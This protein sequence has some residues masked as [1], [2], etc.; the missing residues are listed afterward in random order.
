MN[1]K[2]MSYFE[3]VVV[4]HVEGKKIERFLAYLYKLNIP[5]LN[6][7]YVDRRNIIIKILNRDLDK[8][9]NMKTTYEINVTNYEG[10]LKLREGFRKN[11]FLLS[12]L[13]IGY[14][15]LLVLSNMIFDVEVIHSNANIR[16]LITEELKEHNIKRWSF[17]QNFK[18]IEKIKKEILVEYKDR[19]EWLE[20]ESIGTKYIV[21]VEE[22][23]KKPLETNYIFQDIVSTKNATIAAIYAT[24]GE[25]VKR[26]NDYVKKG[27][28]LI[29][30]KIMKGEEV[31]KIIK[32][33]G[34]IYGE[35]W[36]NIKV[37]YPLIHQSKIETGKKRDIYKVKF[38]DYS[39]S[40]FDFYPFKAKISNYSDIVVNP[41]IP[42][43]IVLDKQREVTAEDEIYT[44]SEALIIA[45]NQASEKME[46][47]LLEDE[48]VIS[49][50]KL[51]Y[52]VENQ[53]LYLQMFFKVYEN[54][55]EPR[56]IT[57]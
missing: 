50:R 25:V 18:G 12:S 57:E 24:E 27:D 52:Y 28:V 55:G 6:I 22:R 4:I 48:H 49:K 35:V 29:S 7:K 1:R 10:K 43:K 51:K 14:I 21:K 36:Y 16:N 32:A 54:I 15:F 45:E 47:Y 19:I 37:E 3:G 31:V 26:K 39:L 8:V 38:L 44:D 2:F 41:L 53:T 13:L 11:L 33:S 56:S 23:K 9:L 5:L 17:K 20:I 40:L 42:F 46:E 34:K 30:G